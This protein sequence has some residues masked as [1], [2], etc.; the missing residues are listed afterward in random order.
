MKS[1]NVQISKE[2]FELTLQVLKEIQNLLAIQD[3]SKRFGYYTEVDR[4]VEEYERKEKSIKLRSSYSRYDKAMKTGTF[5]EQ[6]EA[7]A[8]YL[9][10]RKEIYG[11]KPQN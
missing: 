4:L 9:T 3:L 1:R 11:Y 6:F 8:E 2:T 5:D 10:Q 7:R